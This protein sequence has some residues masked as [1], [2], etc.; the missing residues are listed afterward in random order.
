[1]SLISGI[2]RRAPVGEY[3]ERD[4]VVRRIRA[5]LRRIAVTYGK[6]EAARRIRSWPARDADELAQKTWL[7]LEI[8]AMRDGQRGGTF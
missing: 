6:D 4:E 5:K 1:M 2:Y 3:Q 7:V 8:E